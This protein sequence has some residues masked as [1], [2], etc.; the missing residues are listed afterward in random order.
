MVFLTLEPSMKVHERFPEPLVLVKL[1][2]LI[3]GALGMTDWECGSAVRDDCGFWVRHDRLGAGRSGRDDSRGMA[4]SVLLLRTLQSKCEKSGFLAVEISHPTSP[5]TSL[6]AGTAALRFEMT[7]PL[8]S[9]RTMSRAQSRDLPKWAC[10]EKSLTLSSQLSALNPQPS[11]L[12]P[13]P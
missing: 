12:S 3:L 1:A 2:M 11:A 9:F 10:R 7:Y 13:N 6:R 5:S 4:T 8:L